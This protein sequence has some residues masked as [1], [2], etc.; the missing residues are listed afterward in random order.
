M[1]IHHQSLQAMTRICD[2]AEMLNT[3]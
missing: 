3:L 2:A 1:S